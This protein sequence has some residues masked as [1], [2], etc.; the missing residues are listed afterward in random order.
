MKRTLLWLFL[1]CVIAVILM[2]WSC[3]GTTP[4]GGEQEEEEE[5]ELLEPTP[6]Q[7]I[8]F[9]NGKVVTMESAMPYA[10]ALAV[11][12]E[13]ILA[14]GS[15]E[16]VSAFIGPETDVIDL[17]GKALLP[18]FV[19][20]HNHHFDNALFNRGMTLK[21]AQQVALESGTTTMANMYTDPHV[22]E[23]MQAF[24][25]QGALRVRISLYLNYNDNCGGG[26]R[27]LGDWYKNHSP[28]LDPSAMLRIIGVK[29]FSD[30]G[31]CLRP[32]FSLDLPEWAVLDG[33]QG[34]L[35]VTEEELAA[36][37]NEVQAAGFQAAIH[38]MGD[39]AIETVLNA[40]D[41]ALDGQPNTYR[42]RI[43]HNYNIRPELLTRYGDLGIV[44]VVWRPRTY[45]VTIPEYYM[46]GFIDM[47]GETVRSWFNPWRSLLDANPG[48]HVAWHSDYPAVGDG[49]IPD[50]FG[51]V[52][53][54]Q[55]A[56]DGV[57]VCE[58]PA[59]VAAEAVTVDEALPMMTIEAAYALFMEDWIGSLKPGKFADL[60]VLSD[61]PL[62]VQPDSLIDLK[63]LLT[64]VGGQVEYSVAGLDPSNIGGS[65]SGCVYQSDGSTPIGGATVVAYDNTLLV[66]GTR[67]LRGRAVTDDQGYYMIDGLPTGKYSVRARASEGGYAGE[68]YWNTDDEGERMRVSV[69]A[70]TDTPDVDF[71]LD[72]GG[73]ISGQV[74][75]F[76]NGTPTPIANLDVYAV[77]TQT[78][79]LMAVY[80]TDAR[81][82]YVLGLPAGTYWVR[83]FGPFTGLNFT[84]EWYDD[85]R[86]KG[87][88]TPI[89]VTVGEDTPSI[90]FILSAPV[91]GIP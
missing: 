19:D 52:T 54:N 8:V 34:D 28:V 78:G 66:I 67:V 89:T 51:L 9:I 48:L 27:N 7:D 32:A 68:W 60:V 42:H 86:Y 73:T 87:E 24:E 69:T 81:G 90:D 26:R 23:V 30:G 50:L 71:T 76:D 20:A 38:A 65:I 85:T 6:T 37:I 1:C 80:Y 57:G 33:P 55:R 79:Q 47:H 41:V 31:S 62:T 15:D 2:A 75:Y 61:N 25:Q 40:I 84:P 3:G 39:R 63:V 88:A 77:D 43:E 17:E 83:A 10:E 11:R 46:R 82:H 91:V 59:W 70:P 49:P 22:L 53:G 5:E 4:T 64:M 18:G 45:A 16:E 58:A 13:Y 21:E 56:P 12:G 36:V 29:I 72:V 35:F 14:V 44:A 74:V